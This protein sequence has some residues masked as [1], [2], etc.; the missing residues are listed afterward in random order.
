MPSNVDFAK[1]APGETG[2]DP[3]HPA[4]AKLHILDAEAGRVDWFADRKKFAICGFASSTRHRIPQDDASWIVCGLNQLYRHIRRAD[5]WFDIHA[6]WREGNVEGTDHPRWLAECG[7]PVIMTQRDP[8]IPT[9][10]KQPIDTLIHYFG[11]D[12]FTSTVAHMLALATY[13][14]DMAVMARLKTTPKN[15]MATAWDVY[16]LARS[17]YNEYT[18]GIFGIDLVVGTEYEF[19]R[20]CAEFWI[21]EAEGR[22]IHLEIPPESALCKQLYRYGYQ[23]E[24]DGHPFKLSELEKRR[25]MLTAQKNDALNKLAEGQRLIATIDGALQEE[26]MLNTVGNLR[27]RGARIPMPGTEPG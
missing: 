6:A 18:I 4:T 26:E 14:I 22:G 7:I 1:A 10:V 20:Q 21:G 16:Q 23:M 12:Y 25:Q 13:E 2:V 24:P 11:I 3:K 9:S 5:A 8:S 15:G 19:Q 17:I 27:L